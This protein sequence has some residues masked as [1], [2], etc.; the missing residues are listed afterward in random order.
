MNKPAAGIAFFDMTGC[1]LLMRRPDGT[2]GFPGGGIEDGETPEDAA[3]R[4]TLEETGYVCNVPLTPVGQYDNFMCFKA[5]VNGFDAL[6]NDEHS[7]AD[8]F[9]LKALPTPLHRETGIIL[10][11]A[12]SGEF[13]MDGKETATAREYDINKWFEIQDNPLSKVGVFDYLGRNIPQEKALGNDM[14]AFKVYRPAEELAD[15]ACLESFRLVPWIIDHTMLGDGTNGTTTPDEKGVRGVVGE[16]IWFDPND[17]FGTM[18]GNIKCFSEVLASRI[19]AGKIPLS[20]GYRCIYEYAPGEFNGIPYTYIQRCIRGNHLASVD[21]GRMG[22]EVAVMDSAELSFTFDAKEFTQMKKKPAKK[23][24]P[25]SGVLARMMTFVGDAEEKIEKG[26]DEG[27]ELAQA[28][29][30][31]K[32]VA[33]LLEAVESLQCVGE[34]EA[35]G[36][37]GEK[38]EP[39]GTTDSEEEEGEEGGKKKGGEGSGMDAAEVTRIVNRAVAAALKGV[40]PA[41]AGMDEADVVKSLAQRDKLAKDLSEHVGTFDHSEMTLQRVAEY[42]V[43][44]LE[45]PSRKGGEIDACRAWLHGRPSPRTAPVANAMDAKEPKVGFLSA[46]LTAQK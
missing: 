5:R 32:A 42:G 24:T 33:P 36:A 35:L 40:Q 22:P 19:N 21:D 37:D 12:W 28:V 4:E 27:G 14:V 18:K 8:W 15:A 29:E 10:T 31:I 23:K 16:N 39:A 25:I 41:A 34:S 17:D 6:L 13:A 3:R 20:L 7:Y 45:L 9:S 26:E 43:E 44:K 46:Q 11:D 1:V 2:Y 38:D 30:S